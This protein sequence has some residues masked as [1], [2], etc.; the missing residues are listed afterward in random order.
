MV[1]RELRRKG[2]N[3]YVSFSENKELIIPYDVFLKNYLSVEDEISDK[4][5]RDIELKVEIYRIKQSSFRYL[6]GRN[7]SRYELQVKLMKKKYRKDLINEVLDD[8]ERQQLLSDVE[9]AKL[10]FKALQRRKR[11][12]LK[13][14]SDLYKKGVSREIIEETLSGHQEDEIFLESALI[15]AQKKYNILI[16]RQV[17]NSKINQKI[18]QFLASRGFTSNIIIETLKKIENENQ[19]V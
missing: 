18:F 14:K 13:I 16:K 19:E 17:N 7:H 4:E 6:S 5:I 2:N 11:G 1:V 8:L 10:Y 15:I 3:V 9:F 12:L